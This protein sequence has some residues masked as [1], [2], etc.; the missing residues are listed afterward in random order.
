[1][2]DFYAKQWQGV[3]DNT[4]IPAERA[5]GRVVDANRTAGLASKPT[6]Q[7]YAIGDRMFLGYTPVGCK[8]TDVKL[9]TGTSLGATTVSVGTKDVPD[10]YVAAKTL[11]ATNVPTSLGP[12]ASTLPDAPAELR[13]EIWASFG[14]AAIPAAVN[15]TFE[16]EFVG[17][18]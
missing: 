12:K 16:L 3:A 18:S 11:T 15:M 5:D 1:M 2:A 4:A 9:T 7:A 14:A 8:L 17:I 13:E 6:D 10:K